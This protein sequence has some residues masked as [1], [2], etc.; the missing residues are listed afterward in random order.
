MRGLTSVR[1][2]EGRGALNQ[3]SQ[4]G[5][6]RPLKCIFT[7]EEGESSTILKEKGKRYFL[8]FSFLVAL[9]SL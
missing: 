7:G 4:R 5:N 3:S 2:L 8:F 1:G 9:H 6:Q